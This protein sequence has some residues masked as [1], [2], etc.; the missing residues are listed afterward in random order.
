MCMPPQSS[1]D[2]SKTPPPNP[3]EEA[4]MSTTPHQEHDGTTV[5]DGCGR[6]HH[7]NT[8][9]GPSEGTHEHH[10]PMGSVAHAVEAP[11]SE[12][13]PV[14][15]STTIKGRRPP[16]ESAR[17]TAGPGLVRSGRGQP[18]PAIA[19]PIGRSAGSWRRRLERTGQR[20]RRAE[21]FGGA[22]V[23]GQDEAC[24]SCYPR[25]D[26]MRERK[27]ASSFLFRE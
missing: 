11:A 23:A 15:R 18:W 7:R 17:L 13:K 1:P 10:P 26:K 14:P 19:H 4:P 3:M 12:A 16:E 25:P 6:R 8:C 22:A 20:Q 21:G 2:H 5:I 24:L 27:S 9:S